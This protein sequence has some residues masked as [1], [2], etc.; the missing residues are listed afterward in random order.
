[1][2]IGTGAVQMRP[3]PVAGNGVDE[4]GVVQLDEVVQLDII[5]RAVAVM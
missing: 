4:V 5:L 3:R 1:M 2:Y